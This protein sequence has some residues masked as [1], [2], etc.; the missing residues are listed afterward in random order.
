MFEDSAL[1]GKL[2]QKLENNN[3]QITWT[4]LCDDGLNLARWVDFD[5]ILFHLNQTATAP[6]LE[7][8]QRLLNRPQ[9]SKI[10]LVIIAGQ[11]EMSTP[12]MT[13]NR[14][15]PVYYLPNNAVAENKLLRIIDQ[16]H[17]ISYRYN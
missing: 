7:L 11:P 6:F 14:S 9:L 13:A 17:Y 12:L 1:P 15:A 10:P 16:V 2:K 5:L 3:Y 4:N 8:C